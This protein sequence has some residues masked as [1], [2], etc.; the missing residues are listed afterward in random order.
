MRIVS[1]YAI[2]TG[3]ISFGLLIFFAHA[4]DKYKSIIY[5]I[6]KIIFIIILAA[7]VIVFG[8]I[9]ISVL[10]DR[11]FVLIAQMIAKT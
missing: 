10:F 8:G 2:S 11:V 9:A 3:I 1:G 4:A 6:L 7:C 5:S